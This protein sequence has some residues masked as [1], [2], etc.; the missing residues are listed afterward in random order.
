[1]AIGRVTLTDGSSVP[2]FLCEPSALATA[3]GHHRRRRLA[4]LP[5]PGT[6]GGRQMRRMREKR[7]RWRA[8]RARAP[9]PR[10]G[11]PLP[12]E[13]IL[14]AAAALFV[15]QGFAAAIDAAIAE[16]VGIR[17]ASLYYHFAGKDDIL[18]E[19]LDRSVR[20]SPD[21]RAPGG[22]G[23]ATRRAA[24]ALYALAVID[25]GRWP[26]AAQHRHAVPDARGTGPPVRP[27]SE[28]SGRSCRTFTG[29]WARRRRSRG[30]GRR[31]TA[32]ASASC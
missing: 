17:Q 32:S 26:H 21:S 29:G 13:Q 4:R 7:Q 30:A 25:V 19:L 22:A 24:A 8:G 5:A 31:C 15:G 2:G 1:M 27:R 28:P 3:P 12:R 14:V 23:R 16:P 9:R 20:P 18:A 6:G 11:P 10:P